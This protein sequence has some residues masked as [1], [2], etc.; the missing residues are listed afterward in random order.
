MG[1]RPPREP[2]EPG[3][4]DLYRGDN[5]EPELETRPGGSVDG[6]RAGV[7]VRVA[8]GCDGERR[9]AVP[10]DLEHGLEPSASHGQDAGELP[11]ESEIA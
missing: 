8:V 4:A 11:D 10:F 5:V 1:E 7:R 2:S 9:P 6:E 3:G